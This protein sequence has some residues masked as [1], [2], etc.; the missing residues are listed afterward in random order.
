MFGTG[1]CFGKRRGG[2]LD[3]ADVRCMWVRTIR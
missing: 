3:V 1:D 2:V